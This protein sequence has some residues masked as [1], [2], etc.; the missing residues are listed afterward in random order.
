M[1]SLFFVDGHGD[2]S[3]WDRHRNSAAVL[4]LVYIAGMLPVF[5][6]DESPWRSSVAFE[7]P[8]TLMAVGTG[9]FNTA[10]VI[11]S[12][13]GLDP[14]NRLLAGLALS[15]LYALRDYSAPHAAALA[16]AALVLMNLIRFVDTTGSVPLTT[17][18]LCCQA[19]AALPFATPLGLVSTV[20]MAA[21]MLFLSSCTVPFPLSGPSR[22][23][24][25]ASLPLLYNGTSPLVMG[26]MVA[27]ALPVP[28][29]IVV[30]AGIVAASVLLPAQE[31]RAAADVIRQWRAEKCTLRG[32]RDGTRPLARAIRG[33]VYASTACLVGLYA[34][35]HLLKPT[36]GLSG[37][38]ILHGGLETVSGEGGARRPRTKRRA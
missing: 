25:R 6:H 35:Q 22:G 7:K 20:G 27:D 3:E 33:L 17:A 2:H 30:V 34:A 15:C 21:A 19:C 36:I 18:L 16:L 24:R 28:R 29:P 9:P 26:H 31:K 37:L 5:P 32:W 8:G 1:N 14:Q 38:A 4:A 13:A 23:V 11:G 10:S 12:L